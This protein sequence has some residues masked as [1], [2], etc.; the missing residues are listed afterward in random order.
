M[1]KFFIF[2]FTV[3][4]FPSMGLADEIILND[5]TK[6]EGNILDVDK[7]NGILKFDI[8]LNGELVGMILTLKKDEMIYIKRDDKYKGL[9]KKEITKEENK[10]N[11]AQVQARLNASYSFNSKIQQDVNDEYE[12]NWRIEY[13]EEA[14]KQADLDRQHETEVEKIR[15]NAEVQ[16][17]REAQQVDINN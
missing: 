4:L 12:K 3:M 14:K 5:G 1:N 2:T 6:Y 11:I 10:N 17:A 9:V 13:Y 16:A 15:A 8:V 7:A